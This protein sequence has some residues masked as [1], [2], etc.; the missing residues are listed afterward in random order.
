MPDSFVCVVLLCNIPDEPPV[1]SLTSLFF[2]FIYFTFY[3]V[4]T[5]RYQRKNSNQKPSIVKISVDGSA[6]SQ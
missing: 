1:C 5:I 4:Y 6:S 3:K 2:N